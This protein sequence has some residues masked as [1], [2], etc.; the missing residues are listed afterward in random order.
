MC[1]QMCSW[2][3][4]LGGAFLVFI[5]TQHTVTGVQL[6]GFREDPEG[7]IEPYFNSYA[8]AMFTLFQV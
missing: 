5:R 3:P 8:N 4:F 2:S 1:A 7:I 6:F